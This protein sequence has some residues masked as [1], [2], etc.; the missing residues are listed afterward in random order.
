LF[1]VLAGAFAVRLVRLDQP[2]VENY[3]GRQI[4]TAMVAR[5]LDR[6]SGFLRPSLDTAPF[7]NL[8]LVEPPIYQSL[9]VQLSRF[10][11]WRLE[12][13]G[14]VVSALAMVIAAW[15]LFGLVRRREGE[16]A[17]LVSAAVLSLLPVTLRYGRAFQPDVLMLGLVL[18]G[19]DAW[20]RA[21]HEEGAGWLVLAWPLLAMGLA[22]KVTSAIV[23]VPL[24]LSILGRERLRFC[25]LAALTLI[26]ALA[27]YVWARHLIETA[28]GSQASA[29][30]RAIWQQVFGLSA[31]V[32]PETLTNLW[33]FLVIRAF[34]PLGLGL[35]TLGMSLRPEGRG[36]EGPPTRPDLW[37][38]WGVA[39]LGMLALLASK[40][41]HEYYWLI[42][43]PVVATGVAR[44]ILRLGRG[45]RGLAWLTG[46]A[47]LGMALGLSRSTW[48]TPPEWR[49]LDAAAREI[50]RVVA[51]GTWLVAP[52]ALLFESDRRG[53]RLEYSN[54][55]SMRAASEWPGSGSTPVTTPLELIDFYRAKGARFVADLKAAPSD[56][57]RMALQDAIRRRYKVLVDT[58]AVLVAELS[59]SEIA[60]HDQ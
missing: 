4:P 53:C 52:E 29:Q 50:Q 34:T 20:D 30:N 45:H 43:A 26:P 14:R 22:V 58:H 17:A 3:V 18:A 12:P 49:D 13:C 56:A 54:R 15:G 48:S 32:R 24:G 47:L 46:L 5:N 6:G 8:F 37:R 7:P 23:L 31:L 42:L 41:H 1:A 2:I 11:G 25:L 28:G 51:P 40:L 16:R 57:S 36:D 21:A 35:A 59:P 60:V 39:A 27:W 9:V 33:K 55:A 19:L 38:M 10:G 44:A